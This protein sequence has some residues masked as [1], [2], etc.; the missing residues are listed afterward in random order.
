MAKPALSPCYQCLQVYFGID[1]HL[2]DNH[3]LTIRELQ[4]DSLNM[5]SSQL[6]PKIFIFLILHLLCNIKSVKLSFQ[7]A[8]SDS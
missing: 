6:S 1:A 8:N 3:F 7:Y 4:I 5:G 2:I